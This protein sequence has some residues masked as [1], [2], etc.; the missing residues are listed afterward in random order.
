MDFSGT[1]LTFIGSLVDEKIKEM[2]AQLG[3]IRD[4]RD[5]LGILEVSEEEY[6]IILVT[7]QLN[8]IAHMIRQQLDVP[9]LTPLD[10]LEAAAR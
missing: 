1:D 5:Y 3:S 9:F 6:T 8:R 10:L 4:K 2:E 7:S